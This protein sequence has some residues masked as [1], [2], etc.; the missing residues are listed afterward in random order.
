[1]STE[2]IKLTPLQK[3]VVK[4]LQ[5]GGMLL[6]DNEHK[7]AQVVYADNSYFHIDNGVFWRLVHKCVIGQSLSWP[8]HY[9]LTPVGLGIKI[10]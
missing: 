1:M 9:G 5:G 8:F 3:K 2:K 4:A 7:G 10:E 6:T